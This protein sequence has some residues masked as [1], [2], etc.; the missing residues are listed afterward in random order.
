MSERK[1]KNIF[2]IGYVVLV[3]SLLTLTSCG[4]TQSFYVG[5]GEPVNRGCG[6]VIMNH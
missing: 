5:T 4:S 6:G 2:I 1:S 3:L